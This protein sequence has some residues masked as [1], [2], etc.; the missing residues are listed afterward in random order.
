MKLKKDFNARFIVGLVFTFIGII[1]VPLGYLLRDFG[2]IFY[3][4]FGL[5]GAV[6]L[7]LG[8]ALLYLEREKHKI[9]QKVY[10]EGKYVLAEIVAIK[11]NMNVSING[12]HPCYVECKFINP[13]DNQEY[14]F[15]SRNYTENLDR[16]INNKEVKVYINP[17]NLEDYYVDIEELLRN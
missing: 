17:D 10:D 11:Q 6:F 8:I 12:V 16:L 3:A 1:W 9:T 7:G 13:D 15:K 4:V 5:L 2:F 14:I